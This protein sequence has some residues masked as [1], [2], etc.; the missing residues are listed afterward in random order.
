MFVMRSPSRWAP[1]LMRLSL[2][3]LL[4]CGAMVGAAQARIW[5]GVG[6]PLFV[7][8]R[9]RSGRRHI[10]RRRYYY[11]PPAGYPPPGNTFSYTPGQPSKA[12]RL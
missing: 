2:A 10:T 9:R 7:S 6:I 11:G 3:A 4:L 1:G 8:S 12:W 5:V